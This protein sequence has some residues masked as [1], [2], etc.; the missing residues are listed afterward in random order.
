MRW[1]IA[2]AFSTVVAAGCARSAPEAVPSHERF[3]MPMAAPTTVPE[4]HDRN[5]ATGPRLSYEEA[6]SAARS[7]PTDSEFCQLA[8][9]PPGTCTVGLSALIQ[10]NE[11]AYLRLH[12]FPAPSSHPVVFHADWD[13][14]HD[15]WLVTV[16]CPE[17]GGRGG[18]HAVAEFGY[19]ES[20]LLL[21]LN[22]PAWSLAPALP[23]QSPR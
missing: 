21:P 2:L 18:S 7:F 3:S 13:D 4:P 6:R 10:C 1:W 23:V 8:G 12:T 19:Y 15:R 14:R 22:E 11:D 20:R 9:P 17:T 16:S 5:L